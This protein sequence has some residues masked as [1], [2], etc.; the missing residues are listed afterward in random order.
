M[1]RKSTPIKTIK[2]SKVVEIKE[3]GLM[4]NLK[5]IQN[6]L[7]KKHE[8][9]EDSYSYKFMLD[10]DNNVVMNVLTDEVLYKSYVI[11]V[12]NCMTAKDIIKLLINEVYIQDLNK[13][14][15]YIKDFRNFSNRKAKS[16]CLWSLRNNTKKIEKINTEII[17][18]YSCTT[19][20]KME[21]VNVR[22][23]VRQLY[24]V[25]T[26]LYPTWKSEDLLARYK[27]EIEHFKLNN[28]EVDLFDNYIVV[29]NLAF[30]INSKVEI[31]EYSNKVNTSLLLT[32]DKLY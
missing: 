14:N 19:M 29:S 16:L 21:I 31:Q 15:K 30:N 7:N 8:H 13:M 10:M 23:A 2:T 18:R 3:L 20:T 26:V 12:S 27:K 28:V 1:A 32:M 5:D 6:E 11:K 17:T 22:S 9:E 25:M 24:R 4:D